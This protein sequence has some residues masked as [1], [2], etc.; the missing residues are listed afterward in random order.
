LPD[1]KKI[2][3]SLKHHGIA[4]EAIG[5]LLGSQ[6]GLPL[7]GR[8]AAAAARLAEAVAR[9]DGALPE[10]DLIEIMGWCACCTGGKR[11]DDCKAYRN[12]TTD[13]DLKARVEG[14]SVVRFMGNPRLNEDGTISAFISWKSGESY[15]CPCPCFSGLKMKD[16]VSKTYCLCCA[17]HF[18]HHYINALGV[19]L[20]TIGVVSS[21]LNSGGRMPCEFSYQLIG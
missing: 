12:K 21:A 8:K 7:L 5:S 14:L 16:A 15:L 18:R 4:Q 6:E 2:G 13:L 10:E 19:E 20:R 17:G 3:E 9:M 1:L 11:A